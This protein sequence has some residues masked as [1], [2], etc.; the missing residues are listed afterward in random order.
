MCCCIFK[1]Y[2]VLLSIGKRLLFSFLCCTFACLASH[3]YL[4]SFDFLWLWNY[5]RVYCCIFRVYHAF[6]LMAKWLI[7]ISIGCSWIVIW[8][9]WIGNAAPASSGLQS[10][11][12]AEADEWIVLLKCVDDGDGGCHSHERS[13]GMRSADWPTPV[14]CKWVCKLAAHSSHSDWTA[15]EDESN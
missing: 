13:C 12:Q 6:L 3:T 4:E 10:S 8:F 7:L 14:V 2:H 11:F 5:L 9:A 15:Q 1:V